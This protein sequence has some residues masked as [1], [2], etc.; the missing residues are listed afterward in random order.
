MTM[1]IDW[2][3]LDDDE[4]VLWTGKPRL[5]SIIPNVIIGIPLIAAAGIGL[6]III[7]PY[8]R[9]KNTEFVVTSEG[10]YRKTGTLSR[11]V[12]KIGFDKVQNISFSQNFLGTRFDYGT[13]EVSTAGGSGIELAFR[14]IDDPREVEQVINDRLKQVQG[15]SSTERQVQDS[16]SGDDAVVAELEEIKG[17]LKEINEKLDGA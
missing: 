7:G 11:N 8:L 5:K 12:Q 10:L 3:N 14:N 4:E 2:V 17:L 1:D 9:V 6:L 16:G 13:I 15:S